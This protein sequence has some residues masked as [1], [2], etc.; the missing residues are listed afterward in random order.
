MLVVDTYTLGKLWVFSVGVC[1]CVCV[2]TGLFFVVLHP[3]H[4]DSGWAYIWGFKGSRCDWKSV[5]T[6]VWVC[7]PSTAL[8][9]HPAA[10][11]ILA[12]FIAISSATLYS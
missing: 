10:E 2:L 4:A 6:R 8:F 11:L 1:L 5:Y 3:S 12:Q 9:T 7:V